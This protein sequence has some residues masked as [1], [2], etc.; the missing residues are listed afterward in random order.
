MP[1]AKKLPSGSWRCQAYLGKDQ[2]G[3]PIR[4]SYTADTKKE[5][6]RLAALA[7]ADADAEARAPLTL[8][9]AA[10]AYVAD[11]RGVLA[12][13]TL[14]TYDRIIRTAFAPLNPLPVESLTAERVQAFIS[15]YALTHAPKTTRSVYGL[16]AS[17]LS[18][19]APRLRLRVR[20]P[21]KAPPEMSIPDKS[22][23]DQLLAAAD[24][25]LR[26]AILLA[27]HM[28][29]R[30][31]E[32]SALTWADVRDASLTIRHNLSK[33][34]DKV[35]QVKAPKTESGFRVLPIPP[36]VLP[37]LQRPADAHDQDPV[38]P[39][40]PDA[41]TRRFERLCASLH[42]SYRFHSLRHYYASV[43][44]ALHVPDKYAMQRMGH[45]TPNMLK[46]VYQHLMSD[47]QQ[48]IDDQI[49]TYFS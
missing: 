10:R 38:L 25:E 44:L 1:T 31:A 41:I 17:V 6:E 15:D 30:R 18:F 13:S 43:L 9:Q 37:F 2:N 14:L 27:S 24:P 19:A 35:W 47:A 28:G 39:L 22:V 42:L 4:K 33:G 23:L 7:V 16:L 21:R 12:P 26:L 32:I 8:E 49:N 40:S 46:A 48:Q 3:K 5:A 34:P 36:S 45:A 20:L 29:L 11:R